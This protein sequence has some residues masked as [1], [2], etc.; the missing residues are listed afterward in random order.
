MP[1]R[2]DI[3]DRAQL[4]VQG[5]DRLVQSAGVR[6]CPAAR[7]SELARFARYPARSGPP[8]C[9]APATAS[10]SAAIDSRISAGSAAAGAAEL[11]AS[12]RLRKRVPKVVQVA[13]PA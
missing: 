7:I 8:R 6:V 2:D 5:A 4:P 9:R 12:N 10:A 3:A 11:L 1:Q 13:R